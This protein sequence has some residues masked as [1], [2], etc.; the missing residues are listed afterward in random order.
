MK[1]AKNSK[2]EIETAATNWT[3]KKLQDFDNAHHGNEF[4]RNFKEVFSNER[5]TM[6]A[7]L[8]CKKGLCFTATEKAH[9]LMDTFFSGKQ[10]NEVDLDQNFEQ[11]TNQQIELIH[12][13]E[14]K[15]GRENVWFNEDI[16][17]HDLD[18]VINKL[19]NTAFSSDENKFHPKMIVKSGP[20]FPNV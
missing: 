7:P 12:Q 13:L 19:H 1:L 14:Q 9:V 16:H 18:N 4:W 15:Q 5:N 17:M 20:K 10:L 8:K 11:M 6:I 3:R 2:K